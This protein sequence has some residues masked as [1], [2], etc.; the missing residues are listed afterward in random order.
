MLQAG[1]LADAGGRF[2]AGTSCSNPDA[3]GRRRAPWQYHPLQQS[4]HMR[5]QL[6]AKEQQQLC[7]EQR[8]SVFKLSIAGLDMYDHTVYLL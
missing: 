8:S 2:K 5:E 1:P 4:K 3:Q 6:K 7:G